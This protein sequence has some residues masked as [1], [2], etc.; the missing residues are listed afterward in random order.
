MTP[1]QPIPAWEQR[2]L[3]NR[4]VP[5]KWPG[6]GSSQAT[7]TNTNLACLPATGEVRLPDQV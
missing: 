1:A 4:C 5:R 6:E 2:Q 3:A 7:E